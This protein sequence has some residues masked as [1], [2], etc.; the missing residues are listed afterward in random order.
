MNPQKESLKDKWA[1]AYFQCVKKRLSDPAINSMRNI[2]QLH[3]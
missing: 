1:I 2:I 3:D